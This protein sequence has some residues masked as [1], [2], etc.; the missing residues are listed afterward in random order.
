MIT[1]AKY[2]SSLSTT[3]ACRKEAARGYD[4]G[5]TCDM[6][7]DD[8]TILWH[9]R[10]FREEARRHP[11]FAYSSLLGASLWAGYYAGKKARK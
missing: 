2:D 9:L 7:W 5:L 4:L 3:A 1:I 11:G 8:D 6:P 10:G